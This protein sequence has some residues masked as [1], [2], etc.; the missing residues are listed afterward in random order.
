MGVYG[1]HILP[2]VLDLGMRGE[3]FAERR[4]EALAGLHGRVVELGFGSGL[5]LPHYPPA[6]REILAIEPSS[7]ARRLT[8]GR[9]ARSPIPVRLAGVDGRSL[10]LDDHCVDCVASTWTLCTIPDLPAALAEVRRVLRPGGT[11]HFLEH[12]LSPSP[13][14][15]RW[16]RRLEPFQRRI[17]GGCHLARAF[18]VELEAAGFELLRLEREDM[19]GPR[20]LTHLYRG[21]AR[22]RG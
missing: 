14:V 8:R 10:P 12:G 1:E 13:G 2:R 22:P 4:R 20:V 21:I 16:Q 17:A 7:T 5:N 3:R 11:L 15:A 9:I 6:V 19:P 18:D